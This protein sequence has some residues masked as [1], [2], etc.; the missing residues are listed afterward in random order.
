MWLP[1]Q[2]VVAWSLQFD[3]LPEDVNQQPG[4]SSSPVLAD[5]LHPSDLQQNSE[6]AMLGCE[7]VELEFGSSTSCTKL[8]RQFFQPAQRM[9]IAAILA[10]ADGVLERYDVQCHLVVLCA[11]TQDGGARRRTFRAAS[12]Q[13]GQLMHVLQYLQFSVRAMKS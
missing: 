7:A 13:E 9:P 4:A 6:A 8:P 3:A 1:V 5:D 12:G 11:K 10:P 2:S